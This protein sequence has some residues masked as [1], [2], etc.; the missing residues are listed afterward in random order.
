ME[1]VA[2][3]SVVWVDLTVP[4]AQA[5]RDFYAAVVG[6]ESEP[7]TMGDYQDFNMHPVGSDGP[8]AGICHARGGNATLPPH[9]LVYVR[10]ADLDQA[11]ARCQ[12]LGGRLVDGPRGMGEQR[13]CCIQD[14]AGAY[15]ALVGP[16]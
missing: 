4:N 14:P 12:E 2:A 6:W 15:M 8:A 7:V 9:W 13:F 5:I 11:V 16:R 10:V 3:G 1:P